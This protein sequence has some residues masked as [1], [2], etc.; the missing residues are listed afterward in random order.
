MFCFKEKNINA[1]KS[2]TCTFEDSYTIYVYISERRFVEAER[3]T[4]HCF[5]QSA[6]QTEHICVN[7][8]S[9]YS[10]CAQASHFLA[11]D[12]RNSDSGCI[13]KI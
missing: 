12:T 7:M 5:V 8:L 2:S 11:F 9:P 1:I 13:L 3:M 10:L 6:E 4:A